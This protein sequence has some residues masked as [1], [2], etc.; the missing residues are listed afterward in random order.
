ME[1]WVV[2]AKRAD[3]QGIAEKFG[4]DPVIARLPLPLP[5]P[6]PDFR[7]GGCIGADLHSV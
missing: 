6:Q 3:F 2:T 4:I 5:H 7:L 1:K